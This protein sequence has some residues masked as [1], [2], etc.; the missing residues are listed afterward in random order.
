M[1]N[2]KSYK[3]FEAKEKKDWK[4]LLYNKRKEFK[5]AIDRSLD[6]NGMNIDDILEH[7][8]LDINDQIEGNN[9]YIYK[10]KI[11]LIKPPNNHYSINLAENGNIYL[12]TST[13]YSE[14]TEINRWIDKNK[15]DLKFEYVIYIENIKQSRIKNLDI[16]NILID[17]LEELGFKVN[18]HLY[19]IKAS[20]MID[21]LVGINLKTIDLS[22]LVPANKVDDFEN[23]IIRKNLSRKDAEDI[24]NILLK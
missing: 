13:A 24:V 23:F 10:D 6:F 9:K 3:L 21:N 16:F 7:F 8:L 19:Y 11:S 4:N 1:N 22:D 15:K 17:Y 5:D 20:I 18:H 2:I 12:S 14:Y